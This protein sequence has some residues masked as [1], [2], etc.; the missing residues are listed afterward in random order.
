[1]AYGL[2]VDSL[3]NALNRI[4]HRRVPEVI[5]YDNKTNFVTP[6]KELCEL[7][8]RDLKVQTNTTKKD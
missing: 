6:N 2:D 7:I 8:Y 4:M 5:M 3:L 1:M